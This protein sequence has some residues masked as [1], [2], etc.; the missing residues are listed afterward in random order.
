[1]RRPPPT[2]HIRDTGSNAPAPSNGTSSRVSVLIYNFEFST[3]MILF[4][5][6]TIDFRV[7][8]ILGSHAKSFSTHFLIPVK[9]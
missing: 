3:F 2:L 9:S 7:F 4:N 8:I 1:M 6:K 5:P